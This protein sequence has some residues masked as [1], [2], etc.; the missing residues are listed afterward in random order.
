[1]PKLGG[2][3]PSILGLAPLDVR[4]VVDETA[5]DRR[6]SDLGLVPID[7]AHLNNVAAASCL[8]LVDGV[9]RVGDPRALELDD[10]RRVN[11]SDIY[12]V[13]RNVSDS[14]LFKLVGLT[15][16]YV[17]LVKVVSTLDATVLAVDIGGGSSDVRHVELV[18]T[19]P[20]WAVFLDGGG[21]QLRERIRNESVS[22][23]GYFFRAIPLVDVVLIFCGLV[24]S[25]L[26][27]QVL[28]L[29]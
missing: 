12:L 26:M 6:P 1:L 17:A 16:L 20:L 25:F 5:R 14:I 2:K 8:N 15:L 23:P 21:N 28:L 3:S 13:V 19:E 18:V 29:G 11:V 4:G 7:L 22:S 27:L 10:A 9:Q 24:K